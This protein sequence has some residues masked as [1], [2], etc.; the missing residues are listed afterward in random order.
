[1]ERTANAGTPDVE[2]YHVYYEGGKPAITDSDTS[3]NHNVDWTP[4]EEK[5]LVRKI[6]LILMPLLILPF[7][8]LQ[9]DRGNM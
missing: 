3:S 1:M 9:F 4:E 2:N 6:D 7:M 5:K 8:A